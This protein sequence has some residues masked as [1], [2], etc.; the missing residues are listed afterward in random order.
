MTELRTNEALLAAL[1][2][3]SP[4]SPTFDQLDKQ[5]LSFVM[6]ALPEENEMTREEVQEALERQE[7][8]KLASG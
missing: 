6:G 8:R 3:A 7:G 1:R 4:R 5:R 2:D